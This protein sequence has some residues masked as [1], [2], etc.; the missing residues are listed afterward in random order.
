MVTGYERAK[1]KIRQGK[2]VNGMVT[3]SM[4][5]FVNVTVEQWV[6]FTKENIERHFNSIPFYTP[7]GIRLGD[8]Q[9]IKKEDI[10]DFVLNNNAQ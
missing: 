2:R 7:T 5:A 10:N 1:S 8:G 9:F 3:G 6:E 4:S